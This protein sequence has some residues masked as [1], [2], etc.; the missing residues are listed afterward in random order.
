MNDDFKTAGSGLRTVFIGELVSIAAIFLVWIP[1]LGI[2]AALAGGI[3]VL[4]GLNSAGPA[5]PGF[6]NAFYMA[7]AVVILNVVSA[8]TG[9][10]F[11]TGLLNV[12]VPIVS[13]LETYFICV[14]S[15]ELLLAKGDDSQADRA[16]LIW[17]LYAACMLVGIVCTLVAW[18]PVLNLLAGVVNV[19]VA[20]V[21]LVAGILLFIFLYKASQSLLS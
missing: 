8:F 15:G 13:F 6:K 10:G 11:L 17:K 7:V 18:I 9:A 20:I 19:V 5:H 21:E 16:A 1:F 2:I 3:I 14:A 4:V 12:A